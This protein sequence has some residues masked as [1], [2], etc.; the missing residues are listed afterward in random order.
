MDVVKEELG[1]R[2]GK[3][4]EETNDWVIRRT[5]GGPLRYVFGAI[6]LKYI[7]WRGRTYEPGSGALV[8]NQRLDCPKCYRGPRSTANVNKEGSCLR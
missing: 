7:V 1:K 4:K 5:V 8:Y 6:H 3:G 2:T